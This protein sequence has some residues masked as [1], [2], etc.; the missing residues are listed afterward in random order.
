MGRILHRGH[1]FRHWPQERRP[2]PGCGA[3]CGAATECRRRR[4]RGGRHWQNQI[5]SQ[6]SISRRART[7]A[8]QLPCSRACC[9]RSHSCQTA[10]GCKSRPRGR[11][12]AGLRAAEGAAGKEPGGWAPA[13]QSRAARVRRSRAGS[14]AA[15]PAAAKLQGWLSTAAQA[16]AASA[17]LPRPPPQ[18]SPAAPACHVPGC[19]FTNTPCG[20]RNAA[21][22]SCRGKASTDS[23][24]AATTMNQAPGCAAGVGRDAARARLS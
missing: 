7:P 12:R 21:S 18:P 14:Q 1:A 2:A 10:P 11:R 22:C 9:D 24:G 3:S 8:L 5:S 13:G 23:V 15:M 6:A 19:I 4:R 17:L 20:M 16:L